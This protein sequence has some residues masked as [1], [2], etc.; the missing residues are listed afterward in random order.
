MF[1]FTGGEGQR[2]VG[3]GQS[4]GGKK[5]EGDEFAKVEPSLLFY[6]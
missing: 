5:D 3:K 2:E 1:L 4:S 6:S